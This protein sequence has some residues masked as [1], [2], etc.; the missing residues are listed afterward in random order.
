MLLLSVVDGNGRNAVSYYNQVV[1]TY[2]GND[3]SRVVVATKDLATLSSELKEYIERQVEDFYRV[4]RANKPFYKF[5]KGEGYSGGLPSGNYPQQNLQNTLVYMQ[6]DMNYNNQHANASNIPTNGQ[7]YD[8]YREQMRERITPPPIPVEE[9]ERELLN[10]V[11]VNEFQELQNQDINEITQF[12]ANKINP[13]A[14]LQQ[15]PPRNMDTA[16]NSV[17]PKQF[18]QELGSETTEPPRVP[19]LRQQTQSLTNHFQPQMA[20]GLEEVIQISISGEE[21]F[22][23]YI[24]ISAGDCTYTDGQTQNPDISILTDSQTWKSVI[25]GKVT[26]QKAFM[27]GQLK[28]RGNFVLLAKFEQLFK[29]S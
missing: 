17:L 8:E 9:M 6:E 12:F 13:N 14:H 7:L 18:S 22:E 4:V 1:A 26:A 28:V 2:G 29:I 21:E 5:E 19:T 16:S 25:K 15:L 23:G 27:V 11:G 20:A 3:S 24:T 10:K